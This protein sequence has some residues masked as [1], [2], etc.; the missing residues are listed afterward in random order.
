MRSYAGFRT[1]LVSRLARIESAMRWTITDDRQLRRYA[2]KLGVQP[3]VLAEARQLAGRQASIRREMYQ[4]EIR[5]PKEV[6]DAWRTLCQVRGLTPPSLLRGLI[7]TYLLGER[8]PEWLRHRLAPAQHRYGTGK[9][10]AKWYYRGQL[11]SNTPN[12]SEKAR[13]THGVRRALA[14][15]A[16]VL[17][18]AASDIVRAL[19]LDLLHGKLRRVPVVHYDSLY[20]DE[21]SYFKH[22]AL[23]AVRMRD[24]AQRPVST[25][26]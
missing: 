4:F 8:E 21:S 20:E 14:Q 7:H 10:S 17:R 9:Q 6:F 11:Y 3:S 24:P 22:R 15:R 13:V 12:C 1:W 23:E 19:M 26:I 18:L 16:G 25:E 5:M 2:K